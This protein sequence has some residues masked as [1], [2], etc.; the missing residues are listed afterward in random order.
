MRSTGGDYAFVE[1]LPSSSPFPPAVYIPAIFSCPCLLMS[2]GSVR[3]GSPRTRRL[4]STTAGII[5]EP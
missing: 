1:S 4:Y 5:H 2:V 3:L